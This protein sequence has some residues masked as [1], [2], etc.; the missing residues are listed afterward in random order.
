M[1]KS[2]KDTL[3]TALIIVLIIISTIALIELPYYVLPNRY[4]HVNTDEFSKIFV[5]NDLRKCELMNE[6]YRQ[7][8]FFLLNNRTK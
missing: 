4:I 8:I 2:T 6:Q 3:I 1:E 7:E 5:N